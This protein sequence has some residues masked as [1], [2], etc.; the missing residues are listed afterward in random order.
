LRA[1]LIDSDNTAS[2]ALLR[3]LGGPGAVDAFLTKANVAGFDIRKS[4]A[5]LYADAAADLT[6]AR[7]GDNSATPNAVA[8]L[9][10]GLATQEFT[11]LDSTNELLQ[12]LSETRTGEHGLR[13]GFPADAD[14]AHKSGTSATFG[15]A[16]DATNDAGIL[17]LADGRRVIVVALLGES[18]ADLATREATL[19]GVA[20]AVYRAYAP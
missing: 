10:L 7:G 14:F 12:L 8:N 6:F 13:A 18:R 15:G 5:D 9:L 20:R 11:H 4:E 17:T 19:A 2:D 3:E 1:M 16:T